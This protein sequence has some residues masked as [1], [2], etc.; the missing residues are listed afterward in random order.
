MKALEINSK[1][2]EKGYLKLDYPL[3]ISDKNVRVLVLIDEKNNEESEEVLWLKAISNNPA[4]KFLND[5]EEDIYSLEDGE[6]F[7][8]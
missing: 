8:G 3:N 5:P 2:D 6:D 7:N 4:F 1:T